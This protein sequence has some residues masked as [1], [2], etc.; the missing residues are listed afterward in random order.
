MPEPLLEEYS[1]N[2][3]CRH[4]IQDLEI[5]IVHLFKYELGQNPPLE[6]DDNLGEYMQ[7][8]R[9]NWPLLARLHKAFYGL[10]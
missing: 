10:E 5:F 4:C 9:D 1:K 7:W 3:I 6:L 2:C 8:Q